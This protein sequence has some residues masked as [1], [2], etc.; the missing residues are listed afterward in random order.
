MASLRRISSEGLSLRRG[1]CAGCQIPL[2][3]E[4]GEVEDTADD[5][6]SLGVVDELA[7]LGAELPGEGEELGHLEGQADGQQQQVRGGQR[8]KEH[9]RRALTN[10]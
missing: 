7:E 10:L 6:E 5:T 3:T 9:V 4:P 1:L 2:Y 8:G